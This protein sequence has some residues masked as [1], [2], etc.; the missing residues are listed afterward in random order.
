MAQYSGVKK[1][2][3]LTQKNTSG[4][5]DILRPNTIAPNVLL[6]DKDNSPTLS[7]YTSENHGINLVPSSSR[8]WSEW[9]VPTTNK[10]QIGFDIITLDL[11]DEKEEGDAY[12]TSVEFE[13]SGITVGTGGTFTFYTQ[14]VTDSK[15]GITGAFDGLFHFNTPPQD[16]VQKFVKNWTIN[17]NNVSAK[18]LRFTIRCDYFGSGKFR[19][20]Y[21]KVEKGTI[22]DPVWAPNPNDIAIQ[23]DSL[24][25]K[26]SGRN[27]LLAPTKEG[28]Y[29]SFA[30]ERSFSWTNWDRY[31]EKPLGDGKID[32]NEHIGEYLTYR[33]YVK[34]DE[35]VSGDENSKGISIMFE[36]R[37]ADK[38]NTQYRSAY[39]QPNEEGWLT[40]THVIPDPTI[41]DNPTTFQSIYVSLRKSYPW[42][43]G[44]VTVREAKVEFGQHAT[45]WTPAPEDI[46]IKSDIVNTNNIKDKSITLAK[47]GDDVT[48]QLVTDEEK[49]SWIKK[50]DK[51]IDNGVASLDNNGKVPTAQ[52]PDSILGQLT[53]GGTIAGIYLNSDEVT[54]AAVNLTL[55][56][57]N[58]LKATSNQITIEEF[59]SKIHNIDE[60]MSIYFIVATTYNGNTVKNVSFRNIVNQ[61][62]INVVREDKFS[63]GDWAIFYKS[64]SQSDI[65]SMDK[66]DNTDAVS[67]VNGKTGVVDITKKDLG[68]ENLDGLK[69]FATLQQAKENGETELISYNGHSL[70]YAYNFGESIF[71]NKSRAI[72]TVTDAIKRAL[73]II[74]SDTNIPGSSYTLT[75][76]SN[77]EDLNNVVY[78]GVINENQIA[79]LSIN[80][81]GNSYTA[82]YKNIQPEILKRPRYI[83]DK[84]NI[85]IGQLIRAYLNFFPVADFGNEEVSFLIGYKNK[86]HKNISP[87]SRR[88][89][90]IYSSIPTYTGELYLNDIAN[91]TWKYLLKSYFVGSDISYNEVNDLEPSNYAVYYNGVAGFQTKKIN[92]TY[93]ISSLSQPQNSQILVGY[94]LSRSAQPIN[95]DNIASAQ[96]N[97]RVLVNNIHITVKGNYFNLGTYI[98]KP[99]K[100]LEILSSFFDDG[101]PKNVYGWKGLMYERGIQVRAYIYE[102][103][104]EDE[105][106]IDLCLSYQHVQLID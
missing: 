74:C 90:R 33:A 44:T 8:E 37:Y 55:V 84:T 16:G 104:E 59:T 38:T 97:D 61:A 105:Y 99:V 72:D 98:L 106:L 63:T 20:R 102:H 92:D 23:T 40:I 80:Y 95:L 41:R 5:L 96:R 3:D 25:N 81:I 43:V 91:I 71:D 52:L 89:N 30:E 24:H 75:R 2:G 39:V 60:S 18:Q 15:Y 17:A 32:W 77:T 7:D 85:D 11:P 57:K 48:K 88:N 36:F 56:A 54:N 64:M 87:R 34:Y 19:Y 93:N 35:W 6:E 65:I 86:K 45:Q 51:G 12:T 13:F 58:I 10:I 46:G 53:Y 27:L 101:R 22:K 26:L 79:I 76:C 94:N 29:G 68:I 4:Q 28:N 9:L 67:S 47:L 49:A 14:N 62:D 42:T 78:S 82:Y 1:S 103:Q 66:V 83:G 69:S 50:S 21:L 70:A 31:C 100:D 73:V